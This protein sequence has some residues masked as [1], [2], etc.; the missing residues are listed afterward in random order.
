MANNQPPQYFANH[1]QYVTID[2]PTLKSVLGEL[3]AAVRRGIQ[4]I[5]ANFKGPDVAESEA[6]GTIAYG[7]LGEFA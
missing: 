5:Q 6:F 7:G 2:T 3:R 1:L 4:L